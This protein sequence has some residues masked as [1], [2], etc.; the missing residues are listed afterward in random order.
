MASRRAL[1]MAIRTEDWSSK[2]CALMS[3]M[4]VS[5][6]GNC[7]RVR[8]ARAKSCAGSTNAGDDGTA[9]TTAEA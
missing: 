3:A 2:R 6:D 1:W 5:S 7:N 4:G 9:V 8:M